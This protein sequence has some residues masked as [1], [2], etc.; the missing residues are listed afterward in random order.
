[1]E[2]EESA[3]ADY[4]KGRVP[5]KYILPVPD[6]TQAEPDLL[7]LPIV[8]ISDLHPSSA[9]RERALSSLAD[10]C[11][12]YGSFSMIEVSRSFFKLPLKERERFMSSEVLS[13]VRYGTSFNQTMDGV[14]CWR[15]FLK[16][17]SHPLPE[18][19]SLWPASPPDLREV[20]VSYARETRNLFLD[21]MAAIME[22]LGV[23]DAKM[24]EKFRE[25]SQL[26]PEL[27]LGMPPHSDY[28][29]LTVLLQDGVNGLQMQHQ[30]RWAT[31]NA[32]AI[33]SNGKY[34]SVLHRVFV[35]ATSPRVSVASLH[36]LS[37]AAVVSPSP[38]LVTASE[39]RR[40]MDTGFAAFLHHLSSRG[41]TAKSFLESRKLAH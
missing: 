13:P 36:S 25:G 41:T 4:M 3:E 7:E 16:L 22:T 38:Q 18:V 30:G 9:G 10:A 5:T 39:P 19:L 27:T 24:M 11:R 1:M 14:F 26:M 23:E 35:N 6:R 33:F 2:L 32:A 21:L 40:Y 34:K 37:P 20:A 15:D 31:V 28:G 17:T 12:K 29:F 8:D